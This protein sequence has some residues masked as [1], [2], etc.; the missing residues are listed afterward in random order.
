VRIDE[1]PK[2]CPS[3]D[4]LH[5]ALLRDA[6]VEGLFTDFTDVTLSWVKQNAVP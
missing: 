4:A 6:R 2:N 3:A 1:L 5:A